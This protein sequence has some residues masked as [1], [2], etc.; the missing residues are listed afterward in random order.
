MTGGRCCRIVS[1]ANVT[2]ILFLLLIAV[3]TVRCIGGTIRT[4]L[5]GSA[6][7]RSGVGIGGRL[8]TDSE[9]SA[10]VVFLL[11]LDH[12]R[13]FLP[14]CWRETVAIISALVTRR[15]PPP[16]GRRRRR[17]PTHHVEKCAAERHCDEQCQGHCP[18]ARC[19]SGGSRSLDKI[20]HIEFVPNW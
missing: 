14:G 5:A 17:C 1:G 7:D 2:V 6:R 3:S 4:G 12:G 10:A 15:P 20:A 8:Q 18:H 19:F 11:Y 16:F 9:I 13:L